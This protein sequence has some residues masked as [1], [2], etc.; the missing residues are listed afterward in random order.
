MDKNYSMDLAEILSEHYPTSDIKV[1][2]CDVVK[3][4]KLSKGD[5]NIYYILDGDKLIVLNN[6]MGKSYGKNSDH[7]KKFTSIFREIKL[8]ELGIDE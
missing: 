5:I 6:E 1:G 8:N 2:S 3:T 7:Y 4:I